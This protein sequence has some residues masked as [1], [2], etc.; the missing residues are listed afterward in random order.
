MAEKIKH[1]AIRVYQNADD[2]T[3]PV[4]GSREMVEALKLYMN[5]WCIHT[6][7]VKQYDCQTKFGRTKSSV[8]QPKLTFQD[9][10]DVSINGKSQI[11]SQYQQGNV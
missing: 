6:N 4:S 7:S 9:C 3:V 2:T 11:T 10:T 8:S 5:P 1:I